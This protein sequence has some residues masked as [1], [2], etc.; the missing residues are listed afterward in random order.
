M[1]ESLSV[2]LELR[3]TK[4]REPIYIE[5]DTDSSNSEYLF[6][7]STTDS[8]YDS[9]LPIL[10]TNIRKRER[11]DGGNEKATDA[12]SLSRNAKKKIQPPAVETNSVDALQP[13][14]KHSASLRALPLDVQVAEDPEP[15]PTPISR[16]PGDQLFLPG[17]S[18]L[19]N[20]DME[21]LRQ[22]GL[23]IEHMDYEEFEAMMEVDGEEVGMST[24]LVDQVEESGQNGDEIPV[25]TDY[26]EM[27]ATQIPYND[28]V[29]NISAL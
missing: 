8:V 22:S 16:I 23:G 3:F 21:V 14:S 9:T 11:E 24:K 26:D 27:P 18:Q 7:I 17:A 6:V 2:A 28:R 1:A 4:S 12:E 20:A 5:F 29:K 25:E 19:S 15:H 10:K 13:M